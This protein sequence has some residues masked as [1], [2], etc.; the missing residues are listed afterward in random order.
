MQ[1]FIDGI[2]AMHARNM[3]TVEGDP[4]RA[5][6]ID[7]DRAQTYTGELTAHQEKWIN[8]EAGAVAEMADYMVRPLSLQSCGLNTRLTSARFGA[9]R[10]TT[11]RRGDWIGHVV[12]I[13][14]V[15]RPLRRTRYARLLIRLSIRPA[16][17]EKSR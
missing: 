12:T 14:D 2:K 9:N 6:W 17:A 15:C 10:S 11:S 8:I 1:K 7:F 4:E 13:G 3:M 5:I 16:D